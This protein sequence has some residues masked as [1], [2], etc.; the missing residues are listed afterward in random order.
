MLDSSNATVKKLRFA[1]WMD[2]ASQ[3][4][5]VHLTVRSIVVQGDVN[6]WGVVRVLKEELGSALLTEVDAGAFIH[7][8]VREH[9]IPSFVQHTEVVRDVPLPIAQNRRLADQA[10]VRHM[11]VVRDVSTR[12]VPKVLS[13]LQIIVSNMEVDVSVLWM[14]AAR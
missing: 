1:V 3:L 12:V 4:R 2:V 11:E 13:L 8:V 9:V 14:D 7:F 5:S 10:S 6:I